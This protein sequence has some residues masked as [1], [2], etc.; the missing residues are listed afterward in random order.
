MRGFFEG[1]GM[2]VVEDG[3]R[4]D[5][6]GDDVRVDGGRVDFHVVG[7]DLLG[8]EGWHWRRSVAGGGGCRRGGLL[9]FFFLFFLTSAVAS[10]GPLAMALRM[11]V[12]DF[13]FVEGAEDIGSNG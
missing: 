13:S 9:C 11:A 8:V 3:D 1:G 6:D 5:G 2:G 12:E 4:R 10:A 7:V